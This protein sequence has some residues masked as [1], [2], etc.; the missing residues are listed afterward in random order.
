MTPEE[1]HILL[2]VSSDSERQMKEPVHAEVLDNGNM[3]LLYS[4]GFLQGI[5]AG[6]EFRLVDDN[7]AYEVVKHGGNVCVQVFSLNPIDEFKEVLRRQ[8]APLNGTLDGAID[9]GMVF[10]IP[11]SAGFSKI[12]KVFNDF[13]ASHS[14]T[15]WYFGNVYNP[16]DGTT[17]LN[18]WKK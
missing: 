18:W 14:G 3:K 7:G 5:A 9:R 10:T 16:K 15:E 1:L 11:V 17:P 12:E 2:L 8:V 4:P 13:V 6:D